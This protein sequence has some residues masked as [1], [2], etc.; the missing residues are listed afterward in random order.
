M[1]SVRAIIVCLAVIISILIV[2]TLY[3]HFGIPHF[4]QC[5]GGTTLSFVAH[6]DDDLLF[7]NPD[8][9]KSILAGKCTITV[10]VT[11]GDAG[12]DASYWKNRE[13]GSKASYAAL[14]K[15]SNE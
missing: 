11:A 3:N 12:V 5:M 1:A 14:A 8:I 4:L 6:E 15:L 7:L 2:V 10:F 13:L 9:A